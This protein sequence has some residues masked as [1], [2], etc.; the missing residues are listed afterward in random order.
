MKYTFY[1]SVAALLLFMQQAEAAMTEKQVLAAIKLIRNT[2]KTKTKVADEQIDDTHNGKWDDNDEKLKCYSN[3]VLGMMKMQK[4]NGAPDEES[5]IKQLP[6]LPESMREPFE[7][8]I[9]K[10]INAGDGLTNKCDVAYSFF[11]CLYFDNPQ[12]YFLP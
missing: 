1:C 8:S 12:N 6:Q 5:A 4:K 3:C 7:I 2:C 11:K 10:C 9:K